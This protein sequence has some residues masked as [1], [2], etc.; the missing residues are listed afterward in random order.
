[1]DDL[2]SEE[3]CLISQMM[4][5]QEGEVY[6]EDEAKIIRLEKQ[7]KDW[8][9]DIVA[10]EPKKPGAERHTKNQMAAA[11]WGILNAGDGYWCQGKQCE[12]ARSHWVIFDANNFCYECHHDPCA[13]QAP[14]YWNPVEDAYYRIDER[15]KKVNKNVWMCEP[16]SNYEVKRWWK[17]QKEISDHDDR[18]AEIRACENQQ[19]QAQ[20]HGFCC[21]AHA[22]K[23]KEERRTEELKKKARTIDGPNHCISCDDDPCAFLQIETRLCD[24]D[25]I[26]FVKKEYEADTEA[27]NGI[28]RERAYKYAAYILWGKR[29]FVGF[30]YRCVV[31]GVQSLFPGADSILK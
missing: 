20:D 21:Y 8:K 30:H 25:D 29:G 17:H 26:Y 11:L 23:R 16:K 15:S 3:L 7:I 12:C 22:V 5:L 24:N 31:K 13:C 14:L 2:R 28:R 19:R 18:R 10:K 9:R 6:P 27:Y 4:Y 1:M